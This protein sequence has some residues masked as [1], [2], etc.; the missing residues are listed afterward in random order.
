MKKITLLVTSL[1]LVFSCFSQQ[2][3]KTYDDYME[4]SRK[5]N[6]AGWIFV[7]SGT[8]LTIGGTAL[9][10]SAADSEEDIYDDSWD[11]KVIGGAVMLVAGVALIGTS[12]PFFIMSH[13]YKKKAMNLAFKTEKLQMPRLGK[14][15]NQYYPALSLKIN[16]SR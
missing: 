9:L 3:T 16:L 2:K 12:I 8:A 4:K 11:G 7:G 15:G 13:R 1:F 10:I 5:R 6:T 14:P